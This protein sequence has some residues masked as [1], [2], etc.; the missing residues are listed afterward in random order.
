M[1]VLTDHEIL[2]ACH[3]DRP[4]IKRH[5]P[6]L[7]RVSY[8]KDLDA[9][10]RVISYGPSSAGY[11]IRASDV[12]WEFRP[13]PWWRRVVHSLRGDR[14][15]RVSDAIDPKA[16]DPAK[17]MHRVA[18]I[19]TSAG[20]AYLMPPHSYALTHSVEGF[21]MPDDVLGVCVGKS[22]YARSGLA[23]NVTP[24]EPGWEG[25]LVIE[26]SNTTPRPLLVYVNE[27]I[28]Q[29]QFHRLQSRPTTT[30]GD[31]GGKYQGQRGLTFAKV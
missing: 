28:A 26:V 7:V 2:A 4:M 19:E 18:P 8:T 17:V 21:N 27:G 25:T 10:H 22:T 16:F 15:W 14:G 30:Y 31:R 20:L 1:T 3:G 9:R 6:S 5:V 24:L 23:V 29:I 13:L 12:W 11:D